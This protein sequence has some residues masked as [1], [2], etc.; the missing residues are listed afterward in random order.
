MGYRNTTDKEMSFRETVYTP[1]FTITKANARDIFR[2]LIRLTLAWH[3]FPQYSFNFKRNIN[4]KIQYNIT[5]KLNKFVLYKMDKYLP[6]SE[7]DVQISSSSHPPP[8]PQQSG[9]FCISSSLVHSLSPVSAH[10][11]TL[12]KLG[13]LNPL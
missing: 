9:S 8:D 4:C 7:V 12:P 13:F 11:V 2:H 1:I 10:F 5:L 3:T 6:N